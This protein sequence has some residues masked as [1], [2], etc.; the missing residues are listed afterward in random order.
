MRQAMHMYQLRLGCLDAAPPFHHRAC[1]SEGV[2]VEASAG[3]AED[4]P[5]PRQEPH[6]TPAPELQ[7]PQVC[8]RARQ[9]AGRQNQGPRS[10]RR[11]RLLV[12]QE[13]LPWS[14]RRSV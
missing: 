13:A 6:L 5:R 1:E 12:Q 4:F 10:L 9:V 3:W 2:E 7:S 14:G 8:Q 11:F